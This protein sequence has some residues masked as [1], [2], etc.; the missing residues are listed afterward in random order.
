MC[1]LFVDRKRELNRLRS[2]YERVR[3]GEG[4]V[5][6]VEG[7]VGI[8]KTALVENFISGVED[9]EILRARATSDTRFKP[10]Y[11]FQEALKNYGDLKTIKE[12]QE[13]HKIEDLSQDLVVRPR[14]IFV[15]EIENGGGYALYREV[16]K[17]IDGIYLSIRMPDEPDGIW[18]TETSTTVKRVKPSSL[19]FD[20]IPAIYDILRGDGEK[21]IFI[22]NVNYL[23]YLNGID[24]V[25]DFL[26][27]LYSA[28]VS[29]HVVIVSG[30]SEHLTDEEKNK[31]FACF[32]DVL[33][34]EFVRHR[35]NASMFLVPSLEDVDSSDAVIL[36]SRRGVGK[37]TV[38]ES[39]LDPHRLDF[40]I[41]ETISREMESGHD[42]VLDCLPYLIHY[43]GIRKV[44]VWLKAVADFADKLKR[45]VYVI[46]KGLSDKHVDMIHDLVD[47]SMLIRHV[48]YEDV[49]EAE[50]IKFYDS[51]FNFLDYTSKKR[52]I[53]MLLED[54]QWSDKS[55]LELLRYL[56][57]N[58]GK[59]RILIIGTYR[60]SDLVNDEEAAEIMEDVQNLENTD[61]IRL[62][63]LDRDSLRELLKSQFKF[64][65]EQDVDEIY[66]K[67][68]GNPLLAL[69]IVEHIRNENS[70]VPETIRESVELQLEMLDDRTLHFLTVLSVI[71]EEA[72]V[73][74]VKR[75]YPK[76][77]DRLKK[78]KGKFVEVN[79]GIIRFRFSI[80]RDII[81]RLSSKDTRVEIHRKLG[82]IYE[83]MGEIVDAAKHYYLA[84]DH[85]ALEFLR[86]ASEKSLRDLAIRDAIDYCKMALEIANKYRLKGELASIYE[87]IGDLYR[88]AGEYKKAIEMYERAVKEESPHAVSISVKIAGCYESLGLYDKSL[89]ILTKYRDRA[90]GL[91]KG[92]I[93]GKIGV[94]KWHLGD[95]EEAKQYLEEYL[96]IAR[97]YKSAE[98]MSEAY[99]NM[100]IVHYYFSDYD[101]ALKFAKKALDMAIES[102]RY[103]L[104]ANAYNVV[105][106]IYHRKNLIDDALQYFK[107]YLE[108]VEKLGNYDYI[109]KA[110][111]NLALIYDRMGDFEKARNY[112][113]LSLDFNYKLG[114]KRDLAIS[115]N[116]LAVVESENGDSMKAIEYLKKSL[117]Y[118]EEI[119]DTYNM[120]SAYI[121][122]GSFYHQ[123]RYY[124]E[125]IG[126][127]NKALRIA[128]AENYFDS[129]ISAEITL[130]MIYIEMGNYSEAEKHIKHAEKYLRNSN[131]PYSRLAI[132][133][134]WAELYLS[135][136]DLNKAEEFVEKCIKLSEEIEYSE[137]E[138]YLL[139]LRARIRCARG[140]Y[141]NAT[142]FFEDAIEKE[143]KRNKK[144]WLAEAYRLYAECL[145]KFN[146][147]EAK[148]YYQYAYTLY[149]DLNNMRWAREIEER[150]QKLLKK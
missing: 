31:L 104:I 141:N 88:M 10:Y 85:R 114:N 2:S 94:V 48:K 83:K 91:E 129:I 1:S 138:V 139:S 35:T 148:K 96:K 27:T 112:Y 23:I 33:S 81:Y 60:G 90:K 78:I 63:G 125:A 93:A 121:N 26:H 67:S 101:E 54:L 52:L 46:S 20:V 149:R 136:G 120:C 47:E 14:M 16:R 106:V 22:E 25:V 131:D 56:A 6:L 140:D 32:D 44:F 41:F 76:W 92:R 29:R 105:G 130:A 100:A 134:T 66:E 87:R 133:E 45:R 50:A 86:K 24:R 150:M 124:D 51:I 30:R 109:S 43:N 65:T 143:K 15:D 8:G 147:D 39:P 126:C 11:L 68:E 115:Y 107:K 80:Y 9:A 97:K 3:R 18:L 69:S 113:L 62:R 108:I 102:G 64:L 40:E 55:S 59:S 12:E 95:F 53:I 37:Y 5:V 122:L 36:S 132:M 123:I 79:N 77:K 82:E 61:L 98:D 74:V 111:N 72:P 127:L 144:K 135:M 118:A 28:T 42:I 145:E 119:G 17:E 146:I 137:E 99:R 89:L 49:G 57:R 84:G 128:K 116:N 13:H 34:L 58:I 7:P 4:R 75:I 38:G 21:V 73:D 142:I 103:D 71:G 110:Y 117:K 70:S 19:E